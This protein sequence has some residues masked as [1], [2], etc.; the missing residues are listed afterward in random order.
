[1]SDIF[2]E[3]DEDIRRE[4]LKRIWDRYGIYVIGLAVLI[5]IGTA[6]YRGWEYWQERQAQATG[7]RFVAAI[8]LSEDGSH[9]EAIAAL[10]A[11]KS[12]GGGGYP[13]LAGFRIAAELA[14]AGDT[15]GAVSE[16]DTIAASNAPQLIRQLARLRAAMILVD[17]ASVAELEERIGDLASTGN[18]WR[19]SARELLG[20]AAYRTDDFDRARDYLTQ[21]SEDQES[22]QDMRQ[23]AALVLAVIDARQAPSD[24]AASPEG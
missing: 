4:Q 10:E 15:A 24:A 11:I 18:P 21:I 6:G 13:A 17:S 23:R 9:E 8:Q 16:Y 22:P 20:L 5:V 12:D 19:H 7:D 14:Q 3:V 1:M 2:K